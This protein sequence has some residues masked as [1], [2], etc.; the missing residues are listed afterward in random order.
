MLTCNLLFSRCPRLYMNSKLTQ[1]SC[2]SMKTVPAF[3]AF[4]E[5]HELSGYEKKSVFTPGVRQL[6]RETSQLQER[7][8][9]WF[10]EEL[11]QYRAQPPPLTLSRLLPHTP[12]SRRQPHV[13]E[14]CKVS[15]PPEERGSRGNGENHFLSLSPPFLQGVRTHQSA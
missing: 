9:H 14:G 5:S 10:P 2:V 7:T 13:R 15:L 12:R 3:E 4:G 6:R 11:L 1:L 8:V